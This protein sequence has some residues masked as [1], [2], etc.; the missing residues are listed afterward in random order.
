MVVV[1]AVC[2][3]NN[4]GEVMWRDGDARLPLMLP[5]LQ[6]SLDHEGALVIPNLLKLNQQ[7]NVPNGPCSANMS[8]MV[9]PPAR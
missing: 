8:G 7:G 5:C 4:L 2:D 3:G 1:S 6:F 9:I